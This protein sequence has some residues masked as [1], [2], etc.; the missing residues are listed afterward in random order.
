MTIR[1][2]AIA[3]GFDVDKKSVSKA[4]KAVNEMKSKFTKVLGAIGIGLSLKGLIAQLKK[5]QAVNDAIAD[6]KKRWTSLFGELDKT[7]KITATIA[8]LIRKLSNYALS[9]FRQLM[10]HFQRLVKL[11]GGTPNLLKAIAISAAAIFTAMNFGKITAGLKGVLTLIKAINLKTVA[12]TAVFIILFLLIEDFIGFL[13]GKDSV[14]GDLCKKYGVDADALRA[15]IKGIITKAKTFLSKSFKAIG[16]IL[17]KA[18]KGIAKGAEKAFVIIKTFW[19]N[20]GQKIAKNLKDAWDKLSETF[21]KLKTALKPFIDHLKEAVDK[22]TG[23]EK[24]IDIWDA[25]GKAIEKASEYLSPA[26]EKFGEF[27]AKV[28]EWLGKLEPETLVKLIKG[29]GIAFASFKI[30]KGALDFVGG[31]GKKAELVGKFAEKIGKLKGGTGIVSGFIGKFKSIPKFFGSLGSVFKNMGGVA[32]HVFTTLGG[33]ISGKAA[34]IIAVIIAIIAIVILLIKNWDKIKP[35]I[36]KVIAAFKRFGARVKEIVQTAK[37]KFQEMKDAIKAKIDSIR[38]AFR[39]GFNKIKNFIKEWGL[40]ILAFLMNPL[41][42]IVA[43]V[44]KYREQIAQKIAELKEKIKTIISNIKEAVGTK[45]SEIITTIK[46]K[47]EEIKAWFA[48]LPSKALQWGKDFIQGFINGIT[49]KWQALKDKISSVT[50][51][52]SRNLEHSTPDEG[53]MKDDDKWMPDFMDNLSGGIKRGIPKVKKAVQKLTDGMAF[54]ANVS[55]PSVQTQNISEGNTMTRVINQYNNWTN[56]FNGGTRQ[57]QRDLAQSSEKQT[58]QA[59][60]RLG[61]ELAYTR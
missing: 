11:L 39:N 44:I 3:I 28:A 29:I 31:L 49:A 22:M 34:I 60:R 27:A 7:Y 50:N 2:I 61:V 37:E 21:E 9:K 26:I 6:S 10:P 25:I 48:A 30:S 46:T 19:E 33:L 16:S 56:N 53:P 1:D 38:E 20:H 54:V 57:Q 58:Q 12:I 32:K 51:L 18:F 55:K 35:H 24:S 8:D 47:W 13:Q 41:A 45:V 15:K 36:D 43:L 59:T 17:G 5:A 42:G 23:G 40:V 52:F 14:F 4:D